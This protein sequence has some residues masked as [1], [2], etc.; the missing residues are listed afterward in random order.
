MRRGFGTQSAALYG[1]RSGR[2]SSAR[3]VEREGVIGLPRQ[4]A[5][6]AR[7]SS[8]GS[9]C[10]HRNSCV[11]GGADA[12]DSGEPW[13]NGDARNPSLRATSM[14]SE[15]HE[16]VGEWG[17]VSATAASGHSTSDDANGLTIQSRAKLLLAPRPLLGQEVTAHGQEKHTGGAIPPPSACSRTSSSGSRVA[18]ARR[19]VVKAVVKD[20]ASPDTVNGVNSTRLGKRKVAGK[21]DV[22]R[23]LSSP[24]KAQVPLDIIA[25]LDDQVNV[26]APEATVSSTDCRRGSCLASAGNA[27]QARGEADGEESNGVAPNR[28]ASGDKQKKDNNE[29]TTVGIVDAEATTSHYGAQAQPSMLQ[30][31][32]FPGNVKPAP[33]PLPGDVPQDQSQSGDS[34]SARTNPAALAP[35]HTPPQQQQQQ[36]GSALAHNAQKLMSPA[37]GPSSWTFL[38]T[39]DFVSCL[40]IYVKTCL[41]LR[42]AHIQARQGF[43]ARVQ[44][45][46]KKVLGP[47]AEVRVHGSI[48]TDLALASS[49]IDLLVVG[50]E[51]LT[52][53]QAIQHL[54]RAILH[55]SEKELNELE[56]EEAGEAGVGMAAGR[57]SQICCDTS[58]ADAAKESLD[59]AEAPSAS[60]VDL[61]DVTLEPGA[62]LDAGDP[63]MRMEEEE[64]EYRSQI[65]RD[66][67]FSTRAG[68]TSAAMVTALPTHSP[69]TAAMALQGYMG[70]LSVAPLQSGLRTPIGEGESTVELATM[71]QHYG[72]AGGHRLYV[73]TLG[74]PYFDVQ[75]IISTR[76]PVIKVVEKS[77][78]MRSDITFAGGE[79]WRSMQLTNHMLKRYPASRG[80]ILFLKHCV[81]QMGIGDSQPGGVTSFT[82]YL[83]VLHFF[84]EVSC[85]LEGFLQQQQ[86]EQQAKCESRTSVSTQWGN[87][88]TIASSSGTGDNVSGGVSLSGTRTATPQVQTP[89][90]TQPTAAASLASSWL[91]SYLDK[92]FLVERAFVERFRPYQKEQ[93]GKQNTAS[94][95]H[96]IFTFLQEELPVDFE[97]DDKGRTADL[98]EERTG[99]KLVAPVGY[100]A[101]S[102]EAALHGEVLL[103]TS[104]APVAPDVASEQGGNDDVEVCADRHEDEGEDGDDRSAAAELNPAVEV[105]TSYEVGGG[106]L[107]EREQEENETPEDNKTSLV[108]SLALRLLST[109]SLGHL[110]HDFCFYYG[111]TF[112]Y[113]SH[114]LYF[115]SLGNSSVVPKPRK[116][117][118]RG[119]HLFMTSPFDDQY[120]LTARMLHTREFQELC[121]MFVPLTTPVTTISGYGGGGCSLQEVL[122]WISPETAFEELMQVHTAIQQQQRAEVSG[123][124]LSKTEE[125]LPPLPIHADGSKGTTHA[126]SSL[127]GEV[128]AREQSTSSPHTA[129]TSSVEER[130]PKDTRLP[131]RMDPAAFKNSSSAVSGES[132]KK[133]DRAAAGLTTDVPSAAAPSTPSVSSFSLRQGGSKSILAEP[134]GTDLVGSRSAQA[135]LTQRQVKRREGGAEDSAATAAGDVGGSG[136]TPATVKQPPAQAAVPV[137]AAGLEAA[138]REASPS[139]ALR[140]SGALTPSGLPVGGNVNSVGGEAVYARAQ[141]SRASPMHQP[142][143]QLPFPFSPPVPPFMLPPN[144]AGPGYPDMLPFYFQMPYSSELVM[145]YPQQHYLHQYPSEQR[146]HMHLFPSIGYE[147]H[148]VYRQHRVFEAL[149]G[150]AAAATA[151]SSSSGGSGPT[152]SRQGNT[153]GVGSSPSGIRH[154]GRGGAHRSTASMVASLSTDKAPALV[155]PAALLEE[156]TALMEGTVVE[157]SNSN[158]TTVKDA[159]AEGASTRGRR[160]GTAEAK[161]RLQAEAALASASLAH[162]VQQHPHYFQL[163]HHHHQ[164]QQQQQQ[165]QLQ[166]QLQQQQQQLQQ[167]GLSHQFHHQQQ[168][169]TKLR[170]TGQHQQQALWRQHQQSSLMMPLPQMYALPGTADTSVSSALCAPVQGGLIFR[171]QPNASGTSYPAAATAS[172]F[173][174][175]PAHEV[176]A[177]SSAASFLNENPQQQLQ[178]RQSYTPSHRPEKAVAATAASSRDSSASSNN[179]GGGGPVRLL[180]RAQEGDVGEGRFVE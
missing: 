64:A 42:E 35:Q 147:M 66:Y 165:Q 103:A 52:P 171:Q 118:Q 144:G 20:A 126:Q 70:P 102:G 116:C 39:P 180:H 133:V 22:V 37:L 95:L 167:L 148:Q 97:E 10:E 132:R 41:G 164:Y 173:P 137:S 176:P 98:L 78:G 71:T 149:N 58:V 13:M 84:N 85:H 3:D 96:H 119:Q 145:R 112:N 74:G 178:R 174:R 26:A 122:E 6:R 128:E 154:R 4:W 34:N 117:Q 131:R 8:S 130:L 90:S 120:D 59:D 50:Y 28:N 157:G 166:Q 48:T 89:L 30:R 76:V 16:E 18:A 170:S 57:S 1:H 43:I 25:A 161:E 163:H 55:I 31:K 177:Y 67:V 158:K 127:Q 61:E 94:I 77:T 110:F 81:R 135:S 63:I 104:E 168:N 111:F 83:L 125:Q 5:N 51:P 136:T 100:D 21:P 44:C 27:D 29:V 106:G 40:Q 150:A 152:A 82:I 12:N 142:T 46:V 53:L 124:H 115:D 62:E 17:G 91:T 88:G 69:K 140:A 7:G 33:L 160:P 175:V 19:E 123:A 45:I 65:E 101:A 49:D 109:S 72:G 47:R 36:R 151:A 86:Q 121:R 139:G 107:Q 172:G 169:G 11:I 105:G 87:E 14:P 92:L 24:S 129:P 114:G 143:Q 134:G 155:K 156:P 54:S 68:L 56:A 179:A 108:R 113:D 2:S 32:V 9:R 15:P 138:M 141:L 38:S 162:E 80:L 75:T 23:L 60:P 79:H 93:E 146:H 159:A 99:A 153:R 73:P